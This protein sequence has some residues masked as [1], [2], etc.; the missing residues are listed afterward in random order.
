[1]PD[2]PRNSIHQRELF[3]KRFAEKVATVKGANTIVLTKEEYMEICRAL[4]GWDKLSKQERSARNHAVGGNKAYRWAKR[5]LVRAEIDEDGEVTEYTLLE[6]VVDKP[7]STADGE[8]QDGGE[9]STAAARQPPVQGP[10]PLD[11]AYRIVLHQENMYPQLVGVH[12]AG[13][14]CKARSFD[15]KVK[16]KY[17]RIPRWVLELLCDVC[18]VCVS[19]LH[20]K[21][22]SAGHQPILTKGFGSRGQVDL[23]DLQSCPDGEFKF[24]LNYQDH[25]LKFY[26]NRPLTCKRAGVN[27][28][29]T[30]GC[31]LVHH[32]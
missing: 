7:E 6:P 29:L 22:T 26:D 13:G 14:H 9:A 3:E 19:R 16:A 23:V 27:H 8:G 32:L 4:H 28:A 30:I 5:F 11:Q 21:P 10:K 15:N 2:I 18:R 20:R 31:T 17:S 25:G 24:L 1:M 12:E